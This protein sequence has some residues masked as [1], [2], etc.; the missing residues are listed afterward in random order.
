MSRKKPFHPGTILKEMYLDEMELSQA[1]LA[2]R[3]GCKYAKVNEI[4]NGK[5][6]ITP[7][8]AID[9]E[10]ALKIEA[11]M[12]VSLQGKYDLWKARQKRKQVA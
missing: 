5:R 3:I 2:E 12:W 1:D 4:V 9:L 10:K 8:F 6:G 7:E 11:D